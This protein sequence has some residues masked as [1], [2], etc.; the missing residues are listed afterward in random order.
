MGGKDFIS[1]EKG[2]SL[3]EVLVVIVIIGILVL[4]AIPKFTAIITRAKSTEAKT[5]L[6]HLHMLQQVYYYEHNRYA[7]NLTEVGFEQVTLVTD[8]GEA[9]YQIEILHANTTEY[10]AQ[11][12]A[13]VDFD[14]DGQYNIWQ[15]DQSGIPRQIVLD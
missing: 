7:G 1:D 6:K 10:L 11:A 2:F 4:L 15:I 14:K 13:V 9:R 5:I 8:H 3:T 12:R